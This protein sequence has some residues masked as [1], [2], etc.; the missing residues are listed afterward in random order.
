LLLFKLFLASMLLFGYLVDATN[1]VGVPTGA[2]VCV[3]IASQMASRIGPQLVEE[4]S[5]P[6]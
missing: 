4:R 5:S 6:K 3:V 1:D 2:I